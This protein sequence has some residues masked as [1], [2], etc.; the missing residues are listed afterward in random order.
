MKELTID[1]TRLQ[2]DWFT[3]TVLSASQNMETRVT[4]GGGGGHGGHSAPVRISSTTVVHDQVFLVDRNGKERAFHLTGFS[5]ASRETHK[6][7]VFWVVKK[8]A[9]TGDYVMVQNHTTEDSSFSEPVV[10]KLLAASSGPYM[11]LGILV[12]A[13]LAFLPGGLWF[14][15]A[16]AFVVGSVIHSRKRTRTRIDAFKSSLKQQLASERNA[17][18]DTDRSRPAPITVPAYPAV[19]PVEHSVQL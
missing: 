5:L 12:L 2:L 4:G 9:E 3:G 19:K 11:A 15:L 14:L 16:L 18:L 13:T 7:S 8:G 1:S 17:A 6:L 10:H